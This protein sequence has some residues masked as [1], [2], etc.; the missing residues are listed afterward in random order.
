[1]KNRSALALFF[2]ICWLPLLAQSPTASLPG[3]PA[4]AREAMLRGDTKTAL[5]VLDKAGMETPALADT[6]LY[7]KAVALSQADRRKEAFE[8]LDQLERSAPQSIWITKASFL[9]ADLLRLER[10]FQEAAA[11]YEAQ[12]RR[13]SGPARQ[14]ELAEVYLRF[15]EEL[16]APASA[17]NAK[18]DFAR[19]AD[20]FARALELAAPEALRER[21][22]YRRAQC[23]EALNNP[24]KTLEAY[25]VYLAAFDPT[26]PHAA[27][28]SPAWIFAARL[29]CARAELKLENPVAARR[30]L[31]DLS[32][33]LRRAAAGEGPNAAGMHALSGDKLRDVL[34]LDGE[35]QYA[36]AATWF[37][38]GP[39]EKLGIAA[40]QR[41]LERF[42]AHPRTARA[43]LELGEAQVAANRT[44]DALATFDA[45]LATPLPGKGKEQAV[46][47]QIAARAQY[48]KARALASA[49]RYEEARAAYA[50]YTVNYPSGPDWN[51]AQQG[52]LDSEYELGSTQREREEYEAAK[53]SWSEYLAHHPLDPRAG[54]ILL[55]I[56]ELDA[57]LAA[58]EKTPAAE[59]EGHWRAA[60]ATWRELE[61]KYASQNANWT[62]RA[63]LR[64]AQVLETELG[65]FEGAIAAYRSCDGTPSQGE[66]QTGLRRMLEPALA[67]S[68]E[69]AVLAGEPLRVKIDLR[70]LE[71]LEVELWK[72]DLEAYYRKNLTHAD[73]ESLDL[74][75]ISAQQKFEVPVV[76]A[77]R[78]KPIEQMV[79][80]DVAGPGAWVIAV[81]SGKLRASALCLRSDLDLIVMSTPDETMV[82]VQDMA[83]G[84]P[85][86]NV[87]VLAALG[88]RKG[89]ASPVVLEGKT[90]A[91]G[92]VRFA[93]EPRSSAGKVSVLGMRDGHWASSGVEFPVTPL[94]TLLPRAVVYTDR[95]AYRPGEIVH[96][97]AIVRGARDGR[98]V[99]EPGGKVDLRIDDARGRGVSAETLVQSEY[100]T[101]SGEF[102]LPESSPIGNW[103]MTLTLPDKSAFNASFTVAQFQLVHVELDVEFERSVYYRGEEA[104]A[105]VSARYAHGG[106]VGDSPLAIVLPDG[107]ISEAR[108]DAQGRARI[109]FPTR[110]LAVE[111]LL[112]LS[113]TL[114]DEPLTAEAKTWLSFSEF[115]LNARTA[116]DTYAIDSP[117]TVKVAARGPDG[118]GLARKL[119]LSTLRIVERPGRPR[120][121]TLVSAVEFSSGADGAAA[122]VAK[123]AKS[124]R[125]ILRVSAIDRFGNPVES[126]CEVEIVGQDDVE[127]LRLLSDSDQLVAGDEASVV[128]LE[129]EQGGLALVTFEAGRVLDWRWMKLVP[130]SNSIAFHVSDELAPGFV[131]S[132][133]HQKR[134]RFRTAEIRFDVE[135]E[136]EIAIQPSAEV[137]APGAEGSIELLVRDSRGKP[138]QAELSLAIVDAALFELYPE[139]FVEL[140]SLFQ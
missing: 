99:V 74:D 97:R 28:G 70:N 131:L 19:A 17:P 3:V 83:R 71:K 87:R 84:D 41:F 65:D 13:L 51:E 8:V 66:A 18:P 58:S 127:T 50:A 57:T 75:L 111:Q 11:I 82:F 134:G 47:V 116:Q 136:L 107:R 105:I 119:K 79:D 139:A 16:A 46:A 29:A 72:L 109:A 10:R 118:A 122:P 9:R 21:A 78:Y 76:D 92:Y 4:L 15:A 89:S 80:L 86:A 100:G 85:A 43:R 115:S 67:I 103:T 56:G 73:V 20:L 34:S 33:E 81:S 24:G 120:S 128:A 93:L 27:A 5:E 125:Y 126:E 94:E 106:P 12:A 60:I 108:T 88:E 44:E 98:F 64:I 102:V 52:I 114:S 23:V 36:L 54:E 95:P 129:R 40:L 22:S 124:G 135:R 14:A 63:R 31:E 55:D 39:G 69:R 90:D 61:S 91:R 32:A 38:G 138:V 49:N 140:S 1:M 2:L 48:V 137:L 112:E 59:R 7:L 130:G 96:W 113:V 42:P 30:T 26:H 6:L 110:E 62:G 53:R 123:V 68:I 77:L 132:V 117:F 25:K 35:A 45:I 101:I 104:V 133:A 37:A 121:E